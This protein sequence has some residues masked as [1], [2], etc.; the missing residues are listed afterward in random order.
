MSLYILP[1]SFASNS[2]QNLR[3]GLGLKSCKKRTK[4]KPTDTIINWGE[5]EIS[6]FPDKIKIVNEPLAVSNAVSKLLSF[7]IMEK[8]GVKVPEFTVMKSIAKSWIGKGDIVIGRKLLRA[9]GGRGISVF[10]NTEEIVDCPLYTRYI[11]HK[12]E[13]RIHIFEGEMIDSQQ[14]LKRR[15]FNGD[16]N[17]RIRN[18]D[19]GY[20]FARSGFDVP[21]IVVEEACNAVRA[22]GLN[23][24]AVDIGYNEY[25][26]SAYVFEVNTAPGLEGT[27]LQNY[28]KAMEKYDV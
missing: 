16:R 28:I 6:V 24:G 26:K 23:F 1:Y 20:V 18:L 15:D 13:Y 2:Y 14:K 19:N 22:L 21:S 27:T 10:H 12:A 5:A 4:W 7:V 17:T 25:Y 11:K 3:K 8:A 9:S